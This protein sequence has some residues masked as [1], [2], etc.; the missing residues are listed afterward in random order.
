M[1]THFQREYLDRYSFWSTKSYSIASQSCVHSSDIIFWFAAWLRHRH[2][3]CQKVTFSKF[4]QKT[5]FERVY[6]VEYC[7]KS[8]TFY[9]I[10]SWS[11]V[12]SY[13]IMFWFVAWLRH[14]HFTCQK[15]TFSKFL[16]K[17]RFE[18]VYLDGYCIKSTKSSSIASWSRVH[19]YDTMFWF[20]AWLRHLHFTCQKI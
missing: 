11:R 18:R 14:R 7:F 20:T 16:Q 12:H 5:R 17:T 1:K 8:T 10:A 2:F 13:D 6:L 19:S 9:S 4:L 15:V 3:T